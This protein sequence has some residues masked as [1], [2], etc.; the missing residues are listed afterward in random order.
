MRSKEILFLQT[1]KRHC[2]KRDGAV[3]IFELFSR[4]FAVLVKV[5]F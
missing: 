5:G 1:K 3:R 2:L 4:S